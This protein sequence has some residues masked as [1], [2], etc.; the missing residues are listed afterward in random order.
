MTQTTEVKGSILVVD[1]EIWNLRIL[2]SYLKPEGYNLEMASGGQEALEKIE[3]SNYDLV[4]LDIRM[5]QLD[6]FEVCRRI[7]ANP[8]LQTLP[9]IM[10]SSIRE[11]VDKINGLAAGAHDFL[12]KPVDKAELRARIGAHLRIRTMVKEIEV[13]NQALE[14]RVQERTRELEDSYLITLDALMT[15]LDIRERETGKH[16]LRVAFYVIELARA[17]NVSKDEMFEIAIGALLHDIGK[18]G[19][20]DAVL[21]KPSPLTDDEW[22]IMRQHPGIGWNMVKDIEFAGR[23]RRL[24][25]EHQECWNGDGYPKGL[26]GESIYIGA[27]MF[28][29]IDTLDAI[30]VDRPYRRSAGFREAREE[31]KKNSGIQ[32]D[33]RLVEKFLEIPDKRWAEIRQFV[34]G[35][36]MRDLLRLIQ[37]EY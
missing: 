9:I 27:R 30:T 10:I 15:A 34:Q 24:V 7:R 33:P 23:G 3:T 35:K 5:P 28:G 13:S 2:E 37:E 14:T 12:S 29:I 32:F 25:L 19:I 1:D 21:L 20:P 26:K 31:I 17:M 18:I 4:L 22:M 8:K 6:G 16:S 36:K 11:T